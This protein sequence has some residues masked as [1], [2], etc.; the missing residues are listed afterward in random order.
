VA[1]DSAFVLCHDSTV[2]TELVFD[3]LD[4]KG[5]NQSINQYNIEYSMI[6][7][8][9]GSRSLNTKVGRVSPVH[10]LY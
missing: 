6:L 7:K 3:K 2:S 9:M 8:K 5:I 4:S 1:W 10:R